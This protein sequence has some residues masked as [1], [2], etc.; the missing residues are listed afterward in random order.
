M[1]AVA[2]DRQG[3][4]VAATSTGGITNK[5]AGRVG[6]TPIIGAGTYASNRS[7]A[8]SATGIG[9][10]FI[11]F[12]VARDICARVEYLGAG[13]QAAADE[14]VQGVLEPAGGNGGVVGLDPRGGVIMSFN[15]TGMGRGYV[16]PD[17]QP[18]IR[19]TIDR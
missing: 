17:G 14:V 3:N 6:D 9:E 18:T 11:R 8:I 13:A 7:C 1:G 10:Y 19:L 15:T 4:L 12:T 5:R 2:L 16:G